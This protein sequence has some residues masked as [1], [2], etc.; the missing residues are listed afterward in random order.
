MS[1]FEKVK[2]PSLSVA[3]EN[4]KGLVKKIDFEN[5]DIHLYF[6][7]LRVAVDHLLENEFSA[8]GEEII[9]V[10]KDNFMVLLAGE[11]EEK[12]D[13]KSLRLMLQAINDLEDELMTEF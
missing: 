11:E 8:K 6:K 9:E 12:L 4:L 10:I 13:I 3:M 1:K 7:K 2:N 5:F